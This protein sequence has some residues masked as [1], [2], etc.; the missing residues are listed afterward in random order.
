MFKNSSLLD[1]VEYIVPD[2]NGGRKIMDSLGNRFSASPSSIYPV[3]QPTYDNCR[4]VSAGVAQFLPKRK[5]N[6]N[7]L[8]SPWGAP[9]DTPL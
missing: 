8:N 7:T 1:T 4:S 5:N 3:L 6:K 9:F 2:R